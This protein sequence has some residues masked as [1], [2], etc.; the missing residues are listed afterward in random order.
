MQP[1]VYFMLFCAGMGLRWL[2]ADKLAPTLQKFAHFSTPLVD[3]RDLR[4]LFYSYE[5][6]GEF[7]MGPTQVSQSELYLRLLYHV[8]TLIADGGND[9]LYLVV[10]FFEGLSTI[11]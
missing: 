2:C 5:K 3:I 10:G 1:I 4:E 9:G 8:N 7:F 11:F 6:T